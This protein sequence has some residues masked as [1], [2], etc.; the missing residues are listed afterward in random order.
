MK[1]ND[2]LALIRVA[3]DFIKK[4]KNENEIEQLKIACL[5]N[6]MNSI[7]PGTMANDY[8]QI[9]IDDCTYKIE[10]A[11]LQGYLPRKKYQVFC[12]KQKKDSTE[13]KTTDSTVFSEIE[14][15]DDNKKREWL[16]DRLSEYLKKQPYTTEEALLKENER[17]RAELEKCKELYR[18]EK[19]KNTALKDRIQFTY[20]MNRQSRE[21][22]ERSQN[23]KETI[24][25]QQTVTKTEEKQKAKDI[26][27]EQKENE[28]KNENT[29]GEKENPIVEAKEHEETNKEETTNAQDVHEEQV[30]QEEQEKEAGQDNAENQIETVSADRYDED[31]EKKNEQMNPT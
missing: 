30:A 29:S 28:E 7:T 6:A 25:T 13:Y 19:V 27:K 31:S 15:L 5:I 8:V 21:R 24:E 26:N 10:D 16:L 4:N 17:L 2:I 18:K 1:K 9:Q 20:L 22:N 23:E 11:Y 3:D 14:K 12:K